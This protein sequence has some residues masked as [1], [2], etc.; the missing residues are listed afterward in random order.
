MSGGKGKGSAMQSLDLFRLVI[1]AGSFCVRVRSSPQ[2]RDRIGRRVIGS[3]T[4][5]RTGVSARIGRR[6]RIGIRAIGRR[7]AGTRRM[8]GILGRRAAGSQGKRI[9]KARTPAGPSATQAGILIL[10]FLRYRRSEI[11]CPRN[12]QTAHPAF[13]DLKT[14]ETRVEP[15]C[16]QLARRA[17]GA[18][19]GS[20]SI[21]LIFCLLLSGVVVLLLVSMIASCCCSGH[22]CDVYYSILYYNNILYYMVIAAHRL[23][24]TV[25][26]KA[27]DSGGDGPGGSTIG[28]LLTITY[29]VR[30]GFLYRGL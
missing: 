24:A 3:R 8:A 18:I 23:V 16:K 21:G 11:R 10:W 4:A 12:L 9:G 6:R 15:E 7:R 13:I 20:G 19:C 28:A 17:L 25:L 1:S 29:T 26:Q 5:D 22:C 2:A 30:I 14:S 27:N